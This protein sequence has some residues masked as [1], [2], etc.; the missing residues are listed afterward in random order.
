MAVFFLVRGLL[1]SEARVRQIHGIN[2]RRRTM[3]L[4]LG[5]GVL[6]LVSTTATR[7]GA[8][9]KA[10][11]ARRIGIEAVRLARCIQARPLSMRNVSRWARLPAMPRGRYVPERH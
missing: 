6:G 1:H 5:L 8:R 2:P 3:T 10:G 4:T 11:R 7:R 9:A